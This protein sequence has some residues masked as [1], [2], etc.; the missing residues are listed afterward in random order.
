MRLRN[1]FYAIVCL[2]WIGLFNPIYAESETLDR[3]LSQIDKVGSSLTSM[4]AKIVQK[5]WTDILEEYDSGEKGKFSFLRE[6]GKVHLRKDIVHPTNN[7]LVISDGTVT[8]YQPMIKQAQRYQL[9][10][11]GDKAEF[12]LLGFGSNKEALN[13]AYNIELIGEESVEGRKTYH[14]ELKPKSEQVSA[15]FVSIHLWIDAELWVPIQ[16]RLVEPTQDHLLIRFEEIKLNPK[17][18]KSAFNLKIPR[19]VEVIRN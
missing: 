18:N 8:F 17:I 6:K 5:K 19:D 7:H 9:G 3:V 15:F 16:Q 14:I 12:L 2:S 1:G 13:E 11:H 4:E 10:R